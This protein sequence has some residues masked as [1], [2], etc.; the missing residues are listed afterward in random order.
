MSKEKEFIFKF[1][2][3][4]SFSDHSD[5]SLQKYIFFETEKEKENRLSLQKALESH[6]YSRAFEKIN[7]NI[8][9]FCSNIQI[10]Q[11][12]NLY[13]GSK[14]DNKDK[15]SEIEKIILEA[16]DQIA[17]TF[18]LIDIVKNYEYPDKNQKIENI[19]KAN[20]LEEECNNY[21]KVFNDLTEKI[22]Q[23]NI[24]MINQAKT[25]MRYSDISDFSGEI[26]LEDV[27]SENNNS[28]QNGK[29]F[30]EGI[31]MKKKQND[32]IKKAAKKI[33]NSLSRKNTLSNNKKNNNDY[34]NNEDKMEIFNIDYHK[35]KNDLEKNLL[36]NNNIRNNIESNNYINMDSDDSKRTSKIFH[37]MEDK[38]FLALEGQRQNFL[39]R[40]W[41]ISLI[42][43]I[44]VI[45]LI[46]F[47]LFSKEK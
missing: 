17:E 7:K 21:K 36:S 19:T 15:G 33:E 6:N 1:H 43:L 11:D 39:R 42:I 9:S 26:H 38:V 32:A 12:Y 29:E 16:A 44:M 45:V 46:F 18:I 35:K 24:N 47:L 27:L 40:H 20:S 14:Q 5:N 3:S 41:L 30:L 37:E 4:E 23:Q 28:F 31:E 13:L 10:L 25:S 34:I 2:H 22:K 8:S